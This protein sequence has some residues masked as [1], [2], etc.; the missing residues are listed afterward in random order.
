MSFSTADLYDEHGA[1]LGSCDTQFRS[2]GGL[3]AFSGAAVTVR[4]SEDNVVL[5]SVLSEPGQGRV[6][7]DDGS[8]SLHRALMGDLMARLAVDNGWAG[9]V[10]HGAVRDTAVLAGMPIG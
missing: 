10:V 9:T 8:G 5:K 3:R 4:C 2:F 6:V 1:S 7:V